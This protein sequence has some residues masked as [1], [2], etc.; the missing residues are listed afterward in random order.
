MAFGPGSTNSTAKRW[1]AAYFSQ[2]C[3]LMASVVE[4]DFV[5]LGG[6][7]DIE[8]APQ[9]ESDTKVRLINLTGKTT[10]SEAIG[11]LS[12]SSVF[13]SNDMG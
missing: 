4:A 11:I 13:I 7:E 2:L 1:P 3:T 6:S 10:L 8:A 5:I 9:V 12:L